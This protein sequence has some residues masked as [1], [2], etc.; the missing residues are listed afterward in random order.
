MKE[1][2]KKEFENILSKDFYIHV[3]D[4]FNNIKVCNN[5]AKGFACYKYGRNC[6]YKGSYKITDDLNIYRLYKITD[7]I[8][9]DATII[10]YCQIHFDD[11]GNKL[12]AA[13]ANFVELS[14]A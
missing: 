7:K 11:D 2:S 5:N 6:V 9:L 12:K 1:I 13:K 10:K 14:A 3:L 4:N 8:K